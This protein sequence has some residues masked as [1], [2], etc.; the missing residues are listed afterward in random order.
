M[1]REFEY[2]NQHSIAGLQFIW[3]PAIWVAFYFLSANGAAVANGSTPI[4]NA[5]L[6]GIPAMIFLTMMHYIARG[7]DMWVEDGLAQANAVLPLGHFVVG[8]MMLIIN[9]FQ[10]ATPGAI[11]GQIC[12]VIILLSMFRRTY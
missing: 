6:I 2:E 9:S 7:C 11:V 5:D 4:E 3:A 8:T 12:M 10:L 1:F